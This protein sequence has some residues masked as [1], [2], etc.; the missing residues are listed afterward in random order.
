[1]EQSIIYCEPYKEQ[2][3]REE[4]ADAGLEILDIR[5][6]NK[7]ISLIISKGLTANLIKITL[8]GRHEDTSPLLA[9]VLE[10]IACRL[11]EMGIDSVYGDSEGEEKTK[12][13]FKK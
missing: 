5:P 13:G 6:V 11:A 3:F 8:P 10:R 1:M 12:E 7:M 2:M 4:L 9:P